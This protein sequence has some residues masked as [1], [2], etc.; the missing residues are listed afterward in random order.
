MS[1]RKKWNKNECIRFLREFDAFEHKYM[2]GVNEPKWDWEIWNN[3]LNAQS[4]GFANHNLSYDDEASAA[5]GINQ[6]YRDEGNYTNEYIEMLNL[7]RDRFIFDYTGIDGLCDFFSPAYFEYEWGMHLEINY[8]KHESRYYRDHYVHQIRNMF[9]M[10]TLL[11]YFGYY[12]KCWEAYSN[13]E[14]RVGTHIFEAIEQEMLSLTDTDRLHYRNIIKMRN[15]TADVGYCCLQ[16]EEFHSEL[17]K[18]MFHYVVY[19]ATIIAA[20]VHDIGYPISYIRRISGG[21]GKNLPVCQLLTSVDNDYA[22]IEQALQDTLLFNIVPR[23]KIKL[24]LDSTEEHGAQSAIVLLMYFCQHGSNLSALQRC[25]IDVASL[26][27]YNHTNKYTVIDKP[28]PGKPET[29]PDLHR[30][31]IVKEPLSHIFRMCDDLQEWDRVYF[32]ISDRSNL[33]V[34]PVCGTPLTRLY[35]TDTKSPREKK[36]YCCCKKSDIGYFDT[37]WFVSRRII[38]V[39]A[40]SDMSV[41]K[42]GAATKFIMNYDCGALL[43]IM[44]FSNSFAKY[45]AK[46]VK[47][48]KILHSYQGKMDSVL[49]DSFISGNP[50]IVKIRILEMYGCEKIKQVF[51]ETDKPEDFKLLTTNDDVYKEWR[52]NIAFYLTLR[53]IGGIFKDNCP[54]VLNGLSDFEDSIK[55]VFGF[56]PGD[57][58]SEDDSK[59]FIKIYN[60]LRNNTTNTKVIKE[61]QDFYELL[62]K[63]LNAFA[64]KY[65]KDA[66]I[67]KDNLPEE[68]KDIDLSGISDDESVLSLAAD[69]LLQQVHLIGFEKIKEYMKGKSGGVEDPKHINIYRTLYENLY[70]VSDEVLHAVDKYISRSDY[71]VVKNALIKRH[72][73]EKRIDFFIDYALYVELWDSV[74]NRKKYFFIADDA[75]EKDG[76]KQDGDATYAKGNGLMYSKESLN[77]ADLVLQCIT[78]E[79][80]FDNEY[81]FRVIKFN[82]KNKEHDEAYPIVSLE[83]VLDER[84]G[85]ISFIPNAKMCLKDSEIKNAV[86][87]LFIGNEDFKN[88]HDI[89]EFIVKN[90]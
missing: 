25:A 1:T 68:F 10:F 69:Y 66:I 52:K 74:Q 58:L 41:V 46:C 28:T 62:V 55:N 34:C 26:I 53:R 84:K 77:S 48:L 7:V 24:R 73:I 12:G 33:I 67:K 43:N 4:H 21:I 11:D 59:D 9:E 39:I 83:V 72:A 2:F 20:L 31:D 50:F 87:M 40:C 5:L 78:H 32:E 8:M 61:Y 60:G 22:S 89:D 70:T 29:E 16:T 49:F 81:R 88:H 63:G 75:D 42:E 37:S 80:D 6:V 85:E 3:V 45:R 23:D 18:I 17:R 54:E 56:D 15:D 51:K 64:K 47:Q 36:Y 44:T 86:Q 14:S 82:G 65:I 13:P 19:S 35:N 38:N 27:I 71:E 76:K 30:S 90:Q 79:S 57:I